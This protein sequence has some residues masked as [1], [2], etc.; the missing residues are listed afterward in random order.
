MVGRRGEGAR[1]GRTQRSCR[2]DFLLLSLLFY[3]VINVHIHVFL[4]ALLK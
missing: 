2:S 1:E 3:R 4:N